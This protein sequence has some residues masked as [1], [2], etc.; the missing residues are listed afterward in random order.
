M[1][2]FL[3]KIIIS[4]LNY[5]GVGI[6]EAIVKS[7]RLFHGKLLLSTFLQL[8]FN[9]NFISQF[10]ARLIAFLNIIRTKY[11]STSAYSTR[12]MAR[13]LHF[14]NICTHSASRKVVPTY[15]TN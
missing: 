13:H 10:R 8:L 2:T 12:L 3:F 15:I 4:A 5:V 9:E 14:V 6:C 11:T 1:Q 7:I